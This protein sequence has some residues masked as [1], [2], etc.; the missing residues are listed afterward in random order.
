[1]LLRD[2]C[3]YS[4]DRIEELE[5]QGAFGDVAVAGGSAA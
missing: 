3:G 5:E 1:V 4:D 2:L